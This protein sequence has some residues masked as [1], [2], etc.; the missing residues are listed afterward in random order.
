[1]QVVTLVAIHRQP[2]AVDANTLAFSPPDRLQRFGLRRF[3]RIAQKMQRV[4]DVFADECRERL[5]G[6]EAR[7]RV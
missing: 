2:L 7:W 5:E 6:L 1:V 4:V 3:E